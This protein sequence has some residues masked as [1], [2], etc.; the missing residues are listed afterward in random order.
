MAKKV[1]QPIFRKAE[2]KKGRTFKFGQK[3]KKGEQ[4]FITEK[5]MGHG[6]YAYTAVRNIG[7]TLEF[8][9]TRS[10]FEYTDK[11]K[12]I[13]LVSRISYASRNI[14][15]EATDRKEAERLANEAAGDFEFR[16]H[17]ADYKV[18]SVLSKREHEGIFPDSDIHK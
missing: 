18:D 7:D 6:R 15:V 4:V 14:E 16:E 5:F 13:V 10:E 1:E 8:G 9:V 2:I 12:F 17:D 3:L 11:E